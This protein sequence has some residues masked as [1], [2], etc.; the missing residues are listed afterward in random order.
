MDNGAIDLT[1]VLSRPVAGAVQQPQLDSDPEI[2][3]AAPELDPDPEP[4]VTQVNADQPHEPFDDGSFIDPIGTAESL[5][6]AIDGVQ[7]LVLPYLRKMHVF[8]KKE[9]EVLDTLDTTGSTVYTPADSIE[10]RLLVKYKRHEAILA[11]V[12]FTDSE[13]KRLV[14]GTARYVEQT[15]MKLTPLQALIA[16]FSGVIL[17]RAQLVTME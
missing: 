5:I 7:S 14:N 2:I 12:P 11:K 8:T 16:S 15:D 9:L 3:S 10:A 4:M 17:K 1:N 13:R 6:D